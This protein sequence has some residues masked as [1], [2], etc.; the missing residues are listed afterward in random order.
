MT[1][2]FIHT[3]DL[4]IN[5]NTTLIAQS[6]IEQ[7]SIVPIFVFIKKQIDPKVNKYFSNNMVQFMI[8]SLDELDDSYK[9]K[10]SKLHFFE[11]DDYD[12]VFDK[13]NRKKEINSIGMNFDYSPYAKKRQDA[14]KK[15]CDKKSIVFHCYEDQV[16]YPLLEG[17]T[18]NGSEQAYKVYTP[19]KR[20]VSKKRVA[21]I[22]TYNK[23]TFNKIDGIGSMN[24][25]KFY[26]TN[27]DIMLHGGRKLGLKQLAKVP[28]EQKNYKQK[29]DCLMYETTFLSAYINLN[30]ISIREVYDV[31]KFSEGIVSELI[32]RDFY[33]NILYFYPDVVGNSMTPKYDNIEWRYNNKDFDIWSEGMTGYPIVDAAMRQMNTSGYMHNRCRMIVASFLTKNL[34][35]DWRWGEQYFANMLTD[36]N[37]SSNNGGWSSVTGNAP[38]SLPYFRVFN[39]WSQQKKYDLNCNYIKRWIPELRNIPPD[40]I[41]N[42]E[43]KY[44]EYEDVNYPKPMIDYKKSR[45]EGLRVYKKAVK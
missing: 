37:I 4:R 32:W 29:R 17:N 7:G 20:H 30:V 28:K 11:A 39:P 27:P 25:H 19:F 33:L 44:I 16:L 31:C 13:I 38:H 1:N 14:I 45:E 5:D 3:R 8:E 22:N 24:I 34:L 12:E 6:N 9:K 2:I 10:G 42:W 41:H 26:K 18:L 36:Y 21:S 43:T 40:D 15:W 23:F 35:I